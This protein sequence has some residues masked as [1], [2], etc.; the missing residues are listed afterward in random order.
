MDVYSVGIL[1]IDVALII[2]C[3]RLA[4]AAARRLGQPPV[5]GEIVSGVLLGPTLLGQFVTGVLFPA[6]VRIALV[7]LADIGLML[8]MFGIG[9]E[10]DHRLARR[11][12]AASVA[13][14]SV[15]LP[16]V[17]GTGIAAWLVTRHHPAHPLP[18]VLFMGI[19]MA[20]TAFPVLSRIVVDRGMA[21]THV[22]ALALSSAAIGDVAAWSV[23]AV[24]VSLVGGQPPWLML[25]L[26]PMVATMIGVVRPLLAKVL[27][28]CGVPAALTVLATGL[29]LSSAATQLLGL[30]FIFGAFLFGVV[31][32][33]GGPDRVHQ[34][35]VD[36]LT[37]VGGQLL[38]PVFFVIA[39]LNLNLGRLEVAD[40]G[41]LAAIL[42]VAVGSKL[43]G[44]FAAAT[45]HRLPRRQAGQLAIL[46]NA[47]GLTEIVVLTVGLEAGLLDGRLYS[48]MIVM[49]LVTTAMTG[50]LLS[51]FRDDSVFRDD[52]VRRNPPGT[53]RQSDTPY[54]FQRG[55]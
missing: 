44:A 47:R 36:R 7:A 1:M 48:L 43:A 26:V 38:L 13:T 28:R 52:D 4:G 32:P 54:E 39:G 21:N 9:Y 12:A 40:L 15:L 3:A 35:V 45:V 46:M 23:L 42:A 51:L 37:S 25:L 2:V 8:F 17:L 55:T 16:F 20:V 29:L 33:R 10:L 41:E 18:F 49:A 34:E 5:I 11:P 30:H 6:D 22:G 19:A 27:P 50:P 31:C 53:R 14:G 24:V